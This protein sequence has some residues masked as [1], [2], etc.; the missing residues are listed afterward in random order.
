M[1]KRPQIQMQEAFIKKIQKIDIHRCLKESAIFKSKDF[2]DKKTKNKNLS[3]WEYP[4][5][6]RIN[7]Q[8]INIIHLGQ[9]IFWDEQKNI[10]LVVKKLWLEKF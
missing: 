3:H 2:V 8:K 10:D 9:Y 4:S 7:S 1:E 5:K 6:K